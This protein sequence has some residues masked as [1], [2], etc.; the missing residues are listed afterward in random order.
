[1]AQPSTGREA[2]DALLGT[3]KNPAL[4]GI[5]EDIRKQLVDIRQSEDDFVRRHKNRVQVYL[6]EEREYFEEQASTWIQRVATGLHA[7]ITHATSQGIPAAQGGLNQLK[8]D[9]NIFA[10]SELWRYQDLLKARKERYTAHL[11][12]IERDA[13]EA[14]R[15]NARGDEKRLLVAL[16]KLKMLDNTPDEDT[17]K[18]KI[19]DEDKKR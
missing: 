17:K 5:I 14:Y 13:Y 15:E 8:Y 11:N 12:K 3:F 18:V 10:Y 6:V 1:M 9:L 2:I 16:E 19:E 4:V 7:R